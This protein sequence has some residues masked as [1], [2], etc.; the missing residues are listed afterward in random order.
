M[1]DST[2]DGPEI[3]SEAGAKPEPLPL[4][5]E[6]GGAAGGVV[7]YQYHPNR[8]IPMKSVTES[9]WDSARLMGVRSSVMIAAASSFFTTF[10]AVAFESI[11][12]KS[13]VLGIASFVVLAASLVFVG[14]LVL[15]RRA[16]KRLNARVDERGERP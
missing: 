8:Y 6:E 7:V 5:K 9:E 4:A 12:T 14:L 15:D 2:I 13:G 1:T 11:R 3:R 10:L 16:W